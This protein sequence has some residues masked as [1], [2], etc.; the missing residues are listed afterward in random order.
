MERD[1]E[2]GERGSPGEIHHEVKE[3]ADIGVRVRGHRGKNVRSHEEIEKQRVGRD[4][5]MNGG[6]VS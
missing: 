5:R 6:E 1:V 4:K 2:E 3:G